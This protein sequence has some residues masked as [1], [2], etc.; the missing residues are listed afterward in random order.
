MAEQIKPVAIKYPFWVSL[1]LV[2]SSVLLLNSLNPSDLKSRLGIYIK[3][4]SSIGGELTEIVSAPESE[5]PRDNSFVQSAL[6]VFAA[7]ASINSG[8]YEDS[9]FDNANP[10]MTGEDTLLQNQNPITVPTVEL[11]KPASQPAPY[12]GPSLAGYFIFPTI[13]F[14]QGRLHP[15]NAVDISAGNDCLY[16]NIP[17]FAAASGLMTASY[18][19]ES[20]ARWAGNGY[21]NNLII[22]H[23]NGVITR[24]AHLKSILVTAGQ[25][26]NQGSIIAFMGGYPRTPGSGNSTGCHLHFGVDGAAQPFMR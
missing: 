12:Y 1:F 19:T 25:Y 4:G 18:S 9:E 26:V 15:Y 11:P 7:N 3:T 6:G 24:Y 17:V 23:P 14:N 16:G 10:L 8:I 13:G 21:G 22:L 5:P 20:T 2:F